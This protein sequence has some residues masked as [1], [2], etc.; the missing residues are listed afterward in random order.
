MFWNR[1][2]VHEQRRVARPTFQPQ[3]EC[4]EARTLLDASGSVTAAAGTLVHDVGKTVNDAVH[5]QVSALKQD[6]INVA[7]DVFNAYTEL[8]TP[9]AG[10]N[11]ADDLIVLEAAQTAVETGLGLAFYGIEISGTGA[12]AAVGVPMA[13]VGMDYAHNAAELEAA[14]Y[15]Q[16]VKD[17]LNLFTGGQ[18]QSA[19]T[20]T[21]TPTPTPNAPTVVGT[22]SGS[23]VP[24]DT[25]GS[26]PPNATQKV[27]LTVNAD[28]S[29]NLS[30]VPFAGSGLAVSFPAGSVNIDTSADVVSIDQNLDGI[31]IDFNMGMNGSLSL[32]G[33]LDAYNNDTGDYVFFSSLNLNK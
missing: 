12:G 1:K 15:Q 21:S 7:K 28:G 30:V 11:L 16:A 3:L 17:S 13:V 14:A 26:V 5:L 8:K 29:G 23:A 22:W 4:L 18:Q 6:G 2:H 27:T 24:D 20:P 25:S 32:Q 33:G 9:P 10:G 31:V 19:P